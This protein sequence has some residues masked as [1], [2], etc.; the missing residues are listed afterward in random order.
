MTSH[1]SGVEREIGTQVR[2]RDSTSVNQ[3]HRLHEDQGVNRLSCSFLVLK[4][5]FTRIMNKIQIKLQIES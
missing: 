4:D 3:F 2:L 5:R 1:T